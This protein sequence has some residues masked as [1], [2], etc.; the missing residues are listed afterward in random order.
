[1][2]GFVKGIQ[3]DIET[4]RHNNIRLLT[5]TNMNYTLDYV[6]NYLTNENMSLIY[7]PKGNYHI[8]KKNE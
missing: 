5:L 6:L 2:L 4:N 8:L 1:M 7:L 3:N